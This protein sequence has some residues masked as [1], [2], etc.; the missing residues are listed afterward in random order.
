MLLSNV[1]HSELRKDTCTE[2]SYLYNCAFKNTLS[3]S[4]SDCDA[5]IKLSGWALGTL[6]YG[7]LQVDCGQ[8]R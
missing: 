4:V 3:D 5:A 6:S 2:L 7:Y 1:T 8:W